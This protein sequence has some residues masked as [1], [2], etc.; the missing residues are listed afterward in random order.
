MIT[1]GPFNI[2]D[3]QFKL[4][5]D[6]LYE[7]MRRE[8]SFIFFQPGW[9]ANVPVG[10]GIYAIW[11]RAGQLVYVG[12]TSDLQQRMEDIGHTYNHTCRRAVGIHEFKN[13]PDY[14]NVAACRGSYAPA[15]E[16]AI[17]EY[18]TQ[19]LK[20]AFAKVNVGRKELEYYFMVERAP[21]SHPKYNGV[22]RR[23]RKA[24][25]REARLLRKGA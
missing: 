7:R 20:V 10:A 9:L 13:H 17:T 6:A 24:K 8:A 11:N 12:E 22:T 2:D 19:E 14:F 16:A 5:A 3:A 1:S 23:A 21:C 15:V 4:A 18:F 25:L